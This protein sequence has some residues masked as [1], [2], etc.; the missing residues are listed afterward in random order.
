MGSV[1]KRI[2]RNQGESNTQRHQRQIR[3]MNQTIQD[4]KDAA[5]A[6][7]E[8]QAEFNANVEE[9]LSILEGVVNP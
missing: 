3:N 1:S 6:A 9:R 8:K 4:L 5:L 7:D 2:I